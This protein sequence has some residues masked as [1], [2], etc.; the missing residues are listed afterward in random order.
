V[1]EATV[2]Q[3]QNEQ[4]CLL[5]REWAASEATRMPPEIAG[6]ARSNAAEE[7]PASARPQLSG[8]TQDDIDKG[9]VFFEYYRH[10]W[11]R[12]DY[13]GREGV[14]MDVQG[15]QVHLRLRSGTEFTCRIRD[16]TIL[17]P[18]PPALYRRVKYIG[19]DD[20]KKRPDGAL[21]EMWAVD[22]G[23][24]AVVQPAA[25][26]AWFAILADL[27]WVGCQLGPVAQW[28]DPPI[29]AADR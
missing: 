26:H 4:L 2:D 20:T 7:R 29:P 11:C 28:A 19:P 5:V 3:S 27:E 8:S 1:R 12:D 22:N 21:M 13:S 23:K 18:P 15:R 6:A 17:K 9:R 25:G 14:L 24:L 10:A 16:L